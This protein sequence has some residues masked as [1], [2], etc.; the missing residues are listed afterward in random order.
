MYGWTKKEIEQILLQLNEKAL[1]FEKYEFSNLGQGLNILGQGGSSIVY[2]AGSRK[3]HGKTYA[4]K[5]IGFGEGHVDSAEFREMIREQKKLG[6]YQNCIV[7]ILDF[8]ELRVW[9]EG[10]CEVT[11]VEKIEWIEEEVEEGNFLHLQF[12]IME[13]LIP[14][15]KCNSR[16]KPE[17]FSEVLKRADENEIVKLAYDVGRVLSAVHKKNLLHRDIKLENIFYCPRKKDYKLGDFGIAKKTG[18]GLA[19]TT[20]CTKGY[21]APEVVG[22]LSDKYDNTADIYSFGMVL[23]VLLNELKFP[24]AKNYRPNLKE[25]YSQGYIPLRPVN[26]SEEFCKVIGKMCRFHPDDRYQ[27]MEEVLNDLDKFVY[28]MGAKYKSEHKNALLVLG[29]MFGIAGA[30]MG[31]I[32]FV[33]Y[34]QINPNMWECLFLVLCVGKGILK[35]RGK[36]ITWINMILLM[37]G[38]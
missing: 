37:L 18:N 31:K 27:S 7:E 6:D 17:L 20:A 15:I 19:S 23:Y 36:E 4:V 13:K 32:S 25:Q 12:M 10:Q 3:G 8:V 26:G 11:K 14:V 22:K 24:G 38:S 1:P 28:G 29:T 21:G 16:G 34:M 35:V 5:V 30:L 9:I 33:P 2:E